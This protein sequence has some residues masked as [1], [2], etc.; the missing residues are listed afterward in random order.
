MA[1][2]VCNLSRG[3]C[4]AHLDRSAVLVLADELPDAM[5]DQAAPMHID[6]RALFTPI[7]K[8]RLTVDAQTVASTV[9]AAV[10]VATSDVP[11]PVYLGL[12][13]GTQHAPEELTAA[14]HCTRRAPGDAHDLDIMEQLFQASRKPVLALGIT[15]ARAGVEK[16]LRSIAEKFQV[17]VVLTP[18][19]KGILSEDHP[20]YAGV[21]NHALS[22]RV[23]LTH[24]H[25]DLVVGI[26]YDPVEVNYQDWVPDVPVLHLSTSAA[27]VDT[28]AVKFGVQVIG[29]LDTTLERLASIDTGA[30]SWDV[31]ALASRRA[32]LFAALEPASDRFD[33]R[34]VLKILRERLPPDAIL[35]GDVGAHLHLIGQQWPTPAPGCLLM[36]NAGASMGFGVP[37]AIAAQLCEPGKRVACVTGDGGFL[38][39]VGEMSTARRLAV[40]VVFIVMNDHHHKLIHLKQSQRD[41]RSPGTRLN[42]AGPGPTNHYFGVPV[43]FADNERDYE[44]ALDT[45]LDLNG[46]CVVEVGLDESAYEGLLLRGNRPA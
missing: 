37:A 14:V 10:R 20:L 7:T 25:A 16:L 29:A 42:E 46:P 31:P 23:G 6:Q 13:D 39:T 36:T 18:M 30:K 19:A 21:L 32:A 34:T 2:G 24:Q 27:A 35:A 40:N 15:A 12:P 4:C 28:S 26:G 22:D 11:A 9:A 41:Y 45:A 1:P 5:R 17:P 38:M 3:V 44:N 33:P 8:G 43:L